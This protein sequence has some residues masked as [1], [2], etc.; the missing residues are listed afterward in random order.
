MN[1]PKFDTIDEPNFH[2]HF[3]QKNEHENWVRQWYQIFF[4]AK[5][6]SFLHDLSELDAKKSQIFSHPIHSNHVKKNFS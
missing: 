1:H 3:S 4:A 5:A 2:A 6:I